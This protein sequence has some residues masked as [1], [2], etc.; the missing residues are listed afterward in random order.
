[1]PTTAITHSSFRAYIGSLLAAHNA[2]NMQSVAVAWQIYTLTHDPLDLGLIGLA[3][4]LPAPLLVLLTGH[5]ADRVDRL[6]IVRVGYAGQALCSVLLLILTLR[7]EQAIWHYLLVILAIGTT[8][9]FHAASARALVPNLVPTELIPSAG[10][11]RAITMQIASITGPVIGGLLAGT[12][13][14]L[15]YAVCAYLHLLAA[16][17]L[18]RIR[19]PPQRFS[20]TPLHWQSLTAGLAFI[21]GCR[22]LFGAIT[23]DLFA[24]LFGGATALLPIYARDILLVGADGLGYLRGAMALGAAMTA[25]WLLRHPPERRI[26]LTL[27]AMV[28]LFGLATIGFGLSRNYYWS[29]VFLFVLGAADMVS[30]YIRSAL[31]PLLTPDPMR[32][33]VTAVEMVCIDASNKLGAFESGL[34]AALLGPAPAVVFGGV[35]TLLV[36]FGWYRWFPALYRI[37]RWQDL[38]P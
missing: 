24:V 29:L 25:F 31:V 33:R 23:L 13:T 12:Y 20:D 28:A 1:M 14:F 8:R 30:M 16:W 11:W 21:R 7:A 2:L 34:A 4:F 38:T 15:V 5:V 17:T 37:D 10:A 27:Y 6:R 3:E 9:S 32:G 35:A 18:T 36:V 19:T 26:G 22:P